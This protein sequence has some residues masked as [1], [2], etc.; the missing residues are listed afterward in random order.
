MTEQKPNSTSLT[1][2]ILDTLF[3]SLES[4]DGFDHNLVERLRDLA[5]RDELTKSAKVAGVLK[6]AQGGYDEAH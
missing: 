1:D 5:K 2:Q 4:Q 3:A 6:T